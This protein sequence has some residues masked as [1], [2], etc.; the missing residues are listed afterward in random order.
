MTRTRYP[1]AVMM[2]PPSVPTYAGPPTRAAGGSSHPTDR[3]VPLQGAAVAAP[4]PR[5]HFAVLAPIPIPIPVP[6]L[7]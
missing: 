5:A 1:P 7:R 3:R 2:A 6:V 4:P